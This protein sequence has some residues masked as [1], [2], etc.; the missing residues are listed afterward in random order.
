MTYSTAALTFKEPTPAEV[1]PSSELAKTIHS[2]NK[3]RRESFFHL[4]IIAYGLR[5]QN[6]EKN[7]SKRGRKSEKGESFKPEFKSWYSKEKLDEVYGLLDSGRF[8]QYAMSGRLLNYI[9]WNA[10]N[11]NGETLIQRL[12][13]SANKI[14]TIANYWAANGRKNNPS[15]NAR[16]FNLIGKKEKDGSGVMLYLINPEVTLDEIKEAIGKRVLPEATKKPKSNQ[17]LLLQL[18]SDNSLRFGKTKTTN[19]RLKSA[20]QP[21]TVKNLLKEITVLINKYNKTSKHFQIDASPWKSVEKAIKSDENHAK[22][23][24]S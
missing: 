22:H 2:L 8:S 14:A 23:L 16:L 20:V 13:A 12:P 19:R 9:R 6:L 15:D 5:K 24:E 1:K 18:F 21:E 17:L 7:P 3:T 11:K 4:C 10:P